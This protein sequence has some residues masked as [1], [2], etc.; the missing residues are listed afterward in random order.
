[1]SSLVAK[2]YV[3][4]LMSVISNDEV[5]IFLDELKK[6]SLALQDD[7]SV[8]ILTS[9]DVKNADRE[10]FVLSFKD[11]DDKRYE[12][13]IK[14]LSEKK[15]LLSIPAIYDELKIQDAAIKNEYVGILYSSEEMPADEIKSLEEN[16][17]KK[18]GSTIKLNFVKQDVDGIKIDID[19][20]GVEI[21]FSRERTQETMLEYILK[22]I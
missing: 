16:F 5:S 12:N 15:R 13:F 14:L 10:K 17:S 8:E 22:A 7:K 1:M 11:C 4:G 3:K 18:F 2:R 20:L 9:P 19:S 6:V 21:G